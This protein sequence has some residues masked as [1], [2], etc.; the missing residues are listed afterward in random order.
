MF[1]PCRRF[2]KQLLLVGLML[3]GSV[4]PTWS[5]GPKIRPP[6]GLRSNKV[7]THALIGGKIVVMPGSLIEKGNV[8]IRDGLITAVG[9]EAAVPAD[10]VR[11][12]MTGKI[13]Y[14]GWIDAYSE[15]P[16]EMSRGAINTHGAPYWN[17]NIVPQVRADEIYAADPGLNRALRSQGI[18]TRLVVPNSGL[19]R[20][21]SA[22]VTTGDAD[23][24]ASV[25]Q[26]QTAL[27]QR[28]TAAFGSAG[29]SYPTSPMG[30]LA[31]VRQAWLDADWYD[32]AWKIYRQQK[33]IPRPELSAALEA[34]Q[35]YRGGE[36]TLIVDV[37]DEFYALRAD[38]IS[39]EFQL[40]CVIRGSGSEYRRLDAIKAMQRSFILPVDFPK[41]PG[42]STPEAAASVS[43]ERLMHWDIAP[44]NP[45]RMHAAG[46]PITFCTWGL[47]DVGGFLPA[48]RK[49]VDRGLPKDA[50]LTALTTGAA[51]QY[52]VLDRLGTV[53]AGKLANLFVTDG[54][55]FDAKSKIVET[56]VDGI[57]Y[58]LSEAPG[59]DLR[60]T[61]ELQ[62]AR[63]DGGSEVLTV[64][65]E[66]DAARP[67]GKITRAGKET[68]FASF[69]IFDSSISARFV[70]D[71]LGWPGTVQVTGV[72]VKP[73]T[74]Q[75]PPASNIVDPRWTGTLILASGEKLNYSTKRTAA[76]APPQPM[77]P[78]APQD[79]AKARR[80][81]FAV[82]F[83][84]GD[85]GISG[86]PA[87]PAIVA[88]R[89][90]TVWTCGPEGVIED[91]TVLVQSGKIIGVG[92]NVMVPVGALEV[93]ATGKHLTPG[94]IDCHSHI[95]TDG[96][97]NESGQTITAEVRIGDFIDSN[98]IAIYRQLAGGV[99]SANILHG[100][101][102]T[103]GG[104]NQVIKFRWG[105]LPEE[106]KFA[107][108]PPGIKFAL[109]EN[110]KQSNWGENFS[111]RYPQSRMGVEQL[112]RD[113][114][115]TALR[116]RQKQK[117][118]QG[119][120]QGI[121][122]RVDLELE[123]L[124]EVLEGTRLVHC[125]SYRQDEILA[126]L[127][128]CE[129]F[130]VRVQTLQ[131][132]L[133]GYKLADVMARHGVGGS[134]FADWWA[135]KFEVI[136]AI[137]YNGAVMH[138]AGVVVSFNSDDAEMGRRLNQEAA[139][140]VKYGG[141]SEAEALK[142]VTFNPAVQL[143]ISAKVGSLESGK[144]A[145]LVIW[146]HPPLSAYARCEQTWIDGRKYFDLS[147]DQERRREVAHMRSA[148][149]Q[150]VITSGDPTEGPGD[151]RRESWARE[152]EYCAGHHEH[153]LPFDEIQRREESQ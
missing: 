84:L 77:P 108:A 102:N 113:A 68:S 89:H 110:V 54:D 153:M 59:Y 28:L 37:S 92:K 97:V 25:I 79:P 143:G 85:Y 39:K 107:E 117:E 111:N 86:Q 61:F 82:N 41:A 112:V 87:Q 49:A 130:G 3:L 116:Y 60:G 138:R 150:Q 1:H 65:L 51:T 70:G 27:H 125:H 96:G 45:A 76:F 53:E 128:A 144:D 50:A 21:T 72:L 120:L 114:F 9:P 58:P 81:L 22:L 129:S 29:E 16:A 15:L 90:A 88:F 63:A 91:G 19:I 134:S 42:V 48:I 149:L 133:E 98:D 73:I 139:K 18:T 152:D 136:D 12:D 132:I 6:E 46:I 8:I 69:S 146:S 11:H 99:T 127:R 94:I 106:L 66:G 80:A 17:S 148:L 104:Q 109:G 38:Q 20:G 43:L 62:L 145:D 140:A 78:A 44:E 55:V 13:V 26:Q 71:G 56:W 147:D 137:P 10:A 115:Q 57:P 7:E 142:F 123:A 33:G 31:L 30:A 135:Y 47:G 95:A 32:K 2:S 74:D 75:T 151:R 4:G 93:D 119:S 118:Y 64:V 40:K 141:V 34:M 52:N 121:P 36:K 100:S 105:G 83:P 23:T 103:I 67:T 124:S 14:A 131:H 101:A 126:F 5:A 24:S 122:P 35:G